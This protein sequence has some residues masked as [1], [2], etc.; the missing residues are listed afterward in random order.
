MYFL[1]LALS[2][3][4]RR[5]V[6]SSLCFLAT[7]ILLISCASIGLW[8]YWLIWDESKPVASRSATVFVNAK[9]EGHVDRI[10]EDILFL[11]GVYTARY[12][13]KSEFKDYLRDSFPDFAE[14]IESLGDRVIPDMIE[15]TFDKASLRLTRQ[16]SLQKIGAIPGVHR[17]EDGEQLITSAMRPIQWLSR[18][19]FVLAL[20]LWGVLVLVALGHYQGILQR[21]WEEVQLLRSFGA[22][23]YW[24]LLPWS[25]EALL[26]SLAGALLATA[27]IGLGRGYLSMLFNKFFNILGYEPFTLNQQVFLVLAG[28]LIVLSFTAHLAGGMLAI[29]RGKIA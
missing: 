25:V 27:A 28:S 18:A 29:V 24:I 12:I 22:G 16:T 10:L 15:L 20:G 5:W 8:S 1:A 7:F 19:G 4:K 3:L 17:V 6:T 14:K 9:S 23:R 21:D 2:G 26:H 13:E 11:P